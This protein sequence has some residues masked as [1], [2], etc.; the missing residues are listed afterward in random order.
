LAVEPISGLEV[1]ERYDRYAGRYMM[2]EYKYFA[3]KIQRKGIRGGNVLDIGS[4]SGR[5]AVEL[6]K[7][8][9]G[10]FKIIGLDISREMLELARRN[11]RQAGVGDSLRFIQ[12]AASVLPFPDGS[13]D[14]VISYASLHHWRDPVAV[15]NEVQR[16][17]K[18]EGTII[19]RDNR[20]V[21]G[22]PWWEAFFWVFTRFMNKRQR[23]NWT[24]A[25]LSSYTLPEVAAL[26]KES[27]L[28]GSR[29]GTDFVKFDLSIEWPG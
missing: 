5:L 28:E 17:V 8:G 29:L 26:L 15:F 11:A 1:V 23:D 16:V 14:L 20:R 24:G 6:A 12:A 18:T 13:F 27:R 3:R 10:A 9:R 19:I 7:A 2:P 21:F 22:S 25:I 4:G